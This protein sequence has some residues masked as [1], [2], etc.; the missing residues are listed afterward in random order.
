MFNTSELIMQARGAIHEYDQGP[1]TDEHIVMKLNRAYSFAYNQL[2]SSNQSLFSEWKYLTVKQQISSYP[3]PK[4]MF[5]RR[6]HNIYVPVPSYDTAKPSGW[7]EIQRA[8]PADITHYQ[9]RRLTVYYPYKWTQIGE[10]LVIAPTPIA[11]TVLKLQVTQALVPLAKLQGQITEIRGNI[12]FLDRSPD[13]DASANVNRKGMNLISISDEMTGRVKALYPYSEIDGESITLSDNFNRDA[14]REKRIRR[15]YATTN[16]TKIEYDPLTKE[17]LALL[18]ANPS[19][20]ISVGDTVEVQRSASGSYNIRDTLVTADDFY[21]PPEY[22]LGDNT[23]TV[24]CKVTEVGNNYI[25][26][27]DASCVPDFENGY[28]Y[29]FSDGTFNGNVTTV[30]AGLIQGNAVIL[31]DTATPHRL[32]LNRMFKIDFSGTGTD[33]DGTQR[34]I[35]TGASQLAVLVASYTGVFTP[36]LWSLYQYSPNYVITGWPI[37]YAIAPGT[38][39]VNMID[40]YAGTP[41]TFSILPERTDDTP[42]EESIIGNG[43][44]GIYDHANDVKVGDWVSLGYSTAMP[45]H[46]DLLD[47]LL[48]FYCSITLKSGLN[49]SDPEMLA[50]LKEKVASLFSDT[51]GRNLAIEMQRPYIRSTSNAGRGVR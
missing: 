47:E 12:L 48:I 41:N 27:Q 14:V 2:V 42:D 32:T 35:P 9:S 7:V 6:I 46:S 30:S 16:A 15:A 43:I 29:G 20:Y 22:T 33:M 45:V 10:N 4:D 51:D 37:I 3:L 44:T 50:I 39:L 21:M 18:N 5:N 25:K 24:G 40:I 26:W 17:C 13:A 19:S 23:F 34:V 36:G 1:I 8:D 38:P 28:P 31:L 11:D 49:E